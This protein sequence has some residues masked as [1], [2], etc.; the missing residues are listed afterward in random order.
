VQPFS[1]KNSKLH[2]EAVAVSALARKIGTPFYLY[3]QTALDHQFRSFDAAFATVRHLTCYAV[4]ANSNLAILSLFGRL[5]AGFDVVSKGELMRVL[6]AGMKA[7]K[8]I[9]S[10]VGKT[11]DEI[12]F[13]LQ[14]G[15]LQFNVESAAELAM[16]EARAQALGKAARIALR[17]NPDVESGTHPYIS[18]GTYHHKFGIP[19]SDAIEI[20]VRAR[21]SRHLR[22]TGIACHIGSQITSVKPFEIALLRMKEVFLALRA[23]GIEVRHLDLGGGLGIVYSDEKPPGAGEYARAMIAAVGDLDC[24]LVL[25]PGRAIVGNAGILVTRVVLTKQTGG[26]NFIVVDAGMNDLMRPSLY[27]SYHGIQA[28]ARSNRGTCRADVVGPICESG[29]FFARDREVPVV[30]ANDLLAIMSAGAYGFALASNY[31]TRPRPAEV[32][33]CARKAR[34]IRKREQ[35]RDLIRGESCNPF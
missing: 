15:I 1:Y 28:V 34:I 20:Y 21:R 8:V 26:K 29:D 24:T 18:T 11:E 31:N 14:R 33:V 5:G 22:I 19:V 6:A 32:M 27:G 30:K 9:F 2:C 16:V 23:H 17:V 13:G 7:G 10:G 25:E 3:S 12:D 35:F 4:K